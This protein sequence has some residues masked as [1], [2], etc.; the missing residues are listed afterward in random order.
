MLLYV[1]PTVLARCHWYVYVVEEGGELVHEP[2]VVVNVAP[3]RA[4][5]EITGSAVFVGAISTTAEVAADKAADDG[6]IP[7]VAMTDTLMKYPTSDSSTTYVAPVSD[8]MLL[9]VP[10]MPARCHWYVYVVEEGGELVHEP[11]VVDNVAP[12]R[13]VPEITGSAVFVG[14]ISTTA[15]VAA[16]VADAEPRPFVPVTETLMKYPMSD[17]DT[18]YELFVAVVM[19]SYPPVAVARCH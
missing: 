11:F 17:S 7:F 9:Y 15:V 14:A 18:T 13:A 2:F 19:F 6:P 8:V 1:P 3:V 10:L 16:E 12:L 5:P 4:V